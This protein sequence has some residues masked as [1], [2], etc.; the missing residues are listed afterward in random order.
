LRGCLRGQC[1]DPLTD[2]ERAKGQG[3]LAQFDPW[4]A[5]WET[6]LPA[7]RLRRAT[8]KADAATICGLTTQLQQA[9]ARI[10]KE[11]ANPSGVV[12]LADLHT[13]GQM[14]QAYTAIIASRKALFLRDRKKAF[15]AAMCV[16]SPAH[17]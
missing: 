3:L 2:A 15:N 16:S 4:I 1:G 5:A 9:Q 13:T 8:D 10:A 7:E 17:A 14:V 11:K 12:D 6:A